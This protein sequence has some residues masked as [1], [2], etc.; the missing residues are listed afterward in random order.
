MVDVGDRD[1][2]R[3][4]EQQARAHHLRELVDARRREAPA[5]AEGAQ[6]GRDVEQ[7]AVVVGVRVADV[8][9][10][11]VGAVGV[12]D[13]RGAATRRA[14]APRPSPPRAS[15]S[16]RGSAG[17]AAG[18]GPPGGPSARRPWGRGSRARGRPRR[19]RGRCGRSRLPARRRPRSAPRR[20]GSS[21]RRCARPGRAGSSAGPPANPGS[22]PRAWSRSLPQPAAGPAFLAPSSPAVAD[23]RALPDTARGRIRHDPGTPALP[24]HGPRHRLRL[25]QSARGH[26]RRQALGRA[27]HARPDADPALRPQPASSGRR[28]TTRWGMRSSRT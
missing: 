12:A 20:G 21:G 13:A 3:R 24:R 27:Q 2:E 14:P 19:R 6:E 17:G 16:P 11:R 7:R 8:G 4:A 25:H 5:R 18:P 28:W 1:G 10:D 22:L 23:R 9:A 26:R 15:C